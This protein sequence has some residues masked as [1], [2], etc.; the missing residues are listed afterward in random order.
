[1]KPWEIY[2]FPFEEEKPHPVVILSN[3]E[4]CE[5][6]D[7][8]YVNGLLC[9]SARLQRL[10]KK[11]EIILDESDGLN[12][13]TAVRC[14]FIYALPKADFQERRGEVSSVRRREIARKIAECLRLP[15]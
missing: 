13:K 1:M 4:R 9:T 6:V 14:D 10:P 5:N 8:D 15:L 2:L 12:W 3:M 7:L 11:N